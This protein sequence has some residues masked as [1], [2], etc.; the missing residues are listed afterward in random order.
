VNPTSKDLGDG[1]GLS[2]IKRIAEKHRGK[3]WACS[4]LG[5]GSEFYVELPKS[6]FSNN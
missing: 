5:S 4:K 3:V 2:I 6:P 1:L